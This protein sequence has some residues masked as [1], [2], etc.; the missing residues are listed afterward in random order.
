[1]YIHYMISL[2]LHWKISLNSSLHILASKT[3]HVVL[4]VTHV[5]GY[6]SV[7]LIVLFCILYHV[8]VISVRMGIC[9]LE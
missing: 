8:L 6:C 1:M 3:T 9:L 2:S 5:S 7:P 4:C